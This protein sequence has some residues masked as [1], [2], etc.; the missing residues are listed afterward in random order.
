MLRAAAS[1]LCPMAAMTHVAGTANSEPGIGTGRARPLSSGG[2]NSIRWQ[3]RLS[4]PSCRSSRTGATRNSI[5]NALG[6]RRLDF[7]HEAG[8][9]AAGAAVE[10]AHGFGAQPHGAAAGIHRR[11]AAAHDDHIA[12]HDRR[13]AVGEL[14][15]KLQGGQ[16]PV[17][18]PG[19]PGR[20][21]PGRR[22]PGTPR[23]SPAAGRP[24]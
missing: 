22:S 10:H 5:L 1:T 17:L 2:P 16:W 24:A 13:R 21:S 19:S 12:A 23:R 11:V 8:H 15:E 6:L 3:V 14:F 9:L 7:L 18:R 4:F 20:A